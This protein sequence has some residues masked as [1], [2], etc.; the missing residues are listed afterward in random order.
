MPNDNLKLKILY[1]INDLGPETSSA[2]I[3]HY[4]DCH[5]SSVSIGWLFGALDHLEKAGDIRSEQRPGGPERDHHPKR[6]FWLT[7]EGAAKL[8]AA[9]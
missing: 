7:I 1:A 2:Q 9:H 4:L 3:R 6:V 8:R 5:G